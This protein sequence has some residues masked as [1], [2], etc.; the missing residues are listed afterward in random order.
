MREIKELREKVYAK[1]DQARLVLEQELKVL[2]QGKKSEWDQ[3]QP[4]GKQKRGVSANKN[5]STKK[6]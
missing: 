6:V 2:A 1:D 5:L 4:L 3:K